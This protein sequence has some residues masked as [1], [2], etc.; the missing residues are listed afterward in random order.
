ML[1]VCLLSSRL[2]AFFWC[3]QPNLAVLFCI[4][5]FNQYKLHVTGIPYCVFRAHK[6]IAKISHPKGLRKVT[7]T[8]SPLP[9]S[10]LNH[11]NIAVARSEW[12]ITSTHWRI[13][14]IKRKM[15]RFATFTCYVFLVLLFYNLEKI[16]AKCPSSSAS[17]TCR[18]GPAICPACIDVSWLIRPPFSFQGENVTEGILPGNL[19]HF[20][21][22]DHVFFSVK[23][24][25]A[26][27]G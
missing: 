17:R 1:R 19:K 24:C 22:G 13:V 18:Q 10:K 8:C 7:Q 5:S 21:N 16:E 4:C 23:R 6:T 2:N 25:A 9:S 20:L 3:I 11:R 12:N 26:K 27:L 14:F 15:Y